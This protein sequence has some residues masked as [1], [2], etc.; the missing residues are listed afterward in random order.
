[1]QAEG[2]AAPLDDTRDAFLGSFPFSR[3]GAREFS[4][5]I[6]SDFTVGKNNSGGKNN[7]TNSDVAKRTYTSLA[8]KAVFSARASK[9]NEVRGYGG[10][11]AST[12]FR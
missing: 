9:E 11:Y 1:M 5:G 6:A 10:R 7:N 2:D 4:V 3:A 8:G 12:T